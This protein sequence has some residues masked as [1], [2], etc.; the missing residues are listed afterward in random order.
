MGIALYTL[1]ALVGGAA[2]L[3]RVRR[4]G[5]TP[6]AARSLVWLVLGGFL[7]ANLG[8]AAMLISR[9]VGAALPFALKE[10]SILG[11]VL[12]GA[13][14]ATF[15]CRH[16]HLPLWRAAD[17]GIPALPLALSIARLGCFARGCCYGAPTA[18]W[19][20]L[21][22]PDRAGIWLPRY[23]TQLFSATVNGCIFLTLLAVERYAHPCEG[24]VTLLFLTLF[25]LERFGSEF[26]RGDALP[27]V[28]G[29]FNT[30]HLTC[31]AGL[32]AVVALQ[33]ILTQRRRATVLLAY[34]R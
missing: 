22:L 7:G 11:A 15:L 16:Y 4:G 32:A 12:G 21:F 25:L 19:L 8:G 28:L 24:D 26:L 31:L 9:L 14:A 2:F 17:R 20:G 34:R 29:P 18:S 13:I 23:P 33:S 6:L 3:Y 5:A 27:A 1:A 10:Y 30:T